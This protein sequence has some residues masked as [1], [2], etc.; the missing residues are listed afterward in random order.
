[1][2]RRDDSIGDTELTWCESA[3]IMPHNPRP[4]Y[5]SSLWGRLRQCSVRTETTTDALRSFS[6]LVLSWLRH[7]ATKR[8]V[9]GSMPDEVIEFF[10]LN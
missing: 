4:G 10:Q 8:K 5:M 2:E 3:V 7:Y 6:T 1:M 9:T